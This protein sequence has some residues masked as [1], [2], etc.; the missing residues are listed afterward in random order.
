MRSSQCRQAPF[1]GY[2]FLLEDCTKVHTP[3]RNYEPYFKVDPIFKE[4]SYAKRY[5]VL[6]ERLMLERKTR[7]RLVR[8]RCHLLKRSQMTQ[9]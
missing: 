2:F 5:E 1:L 6:C 7:R 3:V 4:A 8:R 9:V